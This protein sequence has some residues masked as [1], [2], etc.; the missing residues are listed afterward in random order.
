M[1]CAAAILRRQ[2]FH[3]IDHPSPEAEYI[4]LP[5]PSFDAGGSIKGGGDIGTILDQLPESAAVIGGNLDIPPLD[6]YRKLDLLQDPGY[7]AEN[8]AITA[9]C[10]VSIA[11]SRLPVTLR[12]Q[13]VLVIGWGRIGKCLGQLLR[14]LGS[15]VTIA[16]RKETD[17]AMAA[18][19]GYRT[20]DTAEIGEAAQY[21]VIFNTV[22][23]PV[24]D[25]GR[26]ANALKIDL[27]SKQGIAGSDVV[28]AR[29]LPGKDAPESSGAL[30]AETIIR[31]MKEKEA[32][33]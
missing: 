12:D 3:I 15:Q 5:V 31:L 22:P 2:G 16:A 1:D 8:A 28:W 32:E 19:L 9:H 6:G 27:A 17:R 33:L 10:A 7:L 26:G 24:L 14:A 21:R 20:A 4:L 29:G 23:A 11:M 13:R 25:T 30:I 18:A